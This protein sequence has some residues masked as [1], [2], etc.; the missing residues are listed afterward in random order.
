MRNPFRTEAEAFSFVIVIGLAA[1]A[2]GIAAW[3]GGGWVGLG[4]FIGLAFGVLAGIFLRSEPR[5]KEPAVWERRRRD[6]RHH[7]L[8][9]A[10]ETCAGRALLDEVRYRAYGYS[11]EVL[12][13][14]PALT[15]A[16]RYWASD[17]DGARVAAEDRVKASVAALDAAGV[18][19]RGEVGDSDPLQAMEDALR[20]FGADEVIIS[21]HPPG[22]SNWLER[23]V[24]ARARE[25][26]ELP[27][28][29]VIVDLEHEAATIEPP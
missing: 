1:L 26:F 22:R 29:H 3:L 21:T 18:R 6:Q 2:I 15:S 5:V 25:R 17:V 7:I 4:V 28:T 9:V 20:T 23:E 13:V 27:I 24:V 14:A 16:V 12:V 10:N 19:A 11:A 8:V